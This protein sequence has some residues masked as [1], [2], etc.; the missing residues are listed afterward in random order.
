MKHTLHD[1][2]HKIDSNKSFYYWYKKHRY[3]YSFIFSFYWSFI[4]SY[5]SILHI[6]SKDGYLLRALNIKKGVGIEED[7]IE[8]KRSIEQNP[9]FQFYDVIPNISLQS[10]DYIILSFATMESDDIQELLQS[11]KPFCHEKTRIIQES[12]MSWW[13]PVLWITQKLGLRRKTEF[14]NW[15]SRRDLV[16]FA[17]LSDF[18]IV[19]SGGY[20]LLPL[21]IPLLSWLLN[22]YVA[23]L[24]LINRLCLNQWMML[25]PMPKKKDDCV[26]S[27][28]IPCRNER[29]NV[30][31]AVLRCHQ[32]GKETEIIFVE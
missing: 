7:L 32:L 10:F 2:S 25:R 24:P 12:Y 16:N 8:R 6:S 27:V 13:A 11:L 18:E 21:Y 26:V 4:K 5:H 28:I 29:G 31:I 23:Y 20:I 22:N 1:F 15:L 19:S 9:Y 17:Q 30:E 14:K 3:Y